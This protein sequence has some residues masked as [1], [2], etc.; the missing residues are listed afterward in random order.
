MKYSSGSGMFRQT[1]RLP[2]RGRA[3][4]CHREGD[5]GQQ[6]HLLP[7]WTAQVL[8]ANIQVCAD[9]KVAQSGSS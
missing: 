3:G 7:E 1:P 2:R 9:S 4:S 8:I 6:N 5:R